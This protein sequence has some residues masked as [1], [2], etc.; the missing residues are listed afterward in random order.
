VKQDE[1]QD[2][3]SSGEIL[4]ALD[5]ALVEI[6]RLKSRAAE[7]V[8]LI[9]LGCR[10][11]GSDHGADFWN[12]LDGQR[13]G[14]GTVSS[15]RWDLL[16]HG[17]PEPDASDVAYTRTGAFLQ[18][19]D[20]FDAEF[21][22]VSP[23]E[24][25]ALDPQQRLVLEVAWEA[26][27]DAG[28]DS[29]R[30][31]NS[32]VGVFIGM[33][34]MDYATLLTGAPAPPGPYHATGVQ[35]SFASGRVS[36]LLGLRGP[37]LSVNTSCSSSLVSVHLACQ[38]LRSGESDL[39]LAGGVNL[40]LALESS[41]VLC[42]MH[43]LSPEGR[44][45]TF[46]AAADGFVRGEGCGIVVLKRLSD[47]LRDRDHI[48]AVIR[49]SAVNQDGARGG[50]T[51]PNGL[52]QQEVI[53]QALHNGGVSAAEVSYIEAHG[54]GTS[55]GDPIEMG[56]L[57]QVFGPS[58]TPERPL[59]VGSVKTNIGHLEAAAGIAGLIKV[60]L[61][62]Q[63]GQ[64][65]AH[66]HFREPNPHIAWDRLPVRIPT[67]TQ[68]W[69]SYGSR[70]VAGVSSFGMSGTNA[71]VIVEEAPAAVE[72]EETAV[73]RPWH[74]LTVSA[75]TG[76][77]LSALC[78][79]YAQRLSM[80][81]EPLGDLCYTA[82]T[83]RRHWEHRLCVLARDRSEAQAQLS[84]FDR[85]EAAGRWWSGEMTAPAGAVGFVFGAEGADGPHWRALYE[86]QPT[87]RGAVDRCLQGWGGEVSAAGLAALSGEQAL[88][89]VQYGLSE[90]WRS[91]GVEPAV[92]MGVGVGEYAAGVVSGVLEASTILSWLGPGAVAGVDRCNRSDR[93]F[94]SGIYGRVV[95]EEIQEREYWQEVRGRAGRVPE[96]LK[97]MA[98]TGCRVV[99]E[100]GSDGALASRGRELGDGSILWVSSLR[101][102]EP[103]WESV[104]S[105]LAEAY[106]RG[107]SV[108]WRGF[109]R[110]YRRRKVALPTYPWQR[111]RYWVENGT[112][113]GQ[114]AEESAEECGQYEIAWRERPVPRE[115][116]SPAENVALVNVRA[117]GQEKVRSLEAEESRWSRYEQI[118]E[119]LNQAATGQL[120]N[121][122]QGM[123]VSFAS[124]RRYGRDALREMVGVADRHR[125]LWERCMAILCERGIVEAE[126]TEWRMTGVGTEMDRGDSWE[127]L[128]QKY[129]QARQ[130]VSLLTRCTAGLGELLQGHKSAGELLGS[131]GQ[132]KV[133]TS[134]YE[135][136]PLSQMLDGP[137]GEGLGQIVDQYPPD[138]ALRILEIGGGTGRA[139]L[140]M[141][142]RCRGD[143][144]QYVFT[145]RSGLL[146]AG[147][148]ERLS[149]YP[150]VRYELL[151]IEQR[152]EDQGQ[153]RS[154]YDVIVASNVIHVTRDVQESLRHIH[155]LLAPGGILLLQEAVKPQVWVDLTVGLDERWWSYRDEAVRGSYPL[156]SR[157][158]WQSQLEGLGFSEC[159]WVGPEGC[160]QQLLMA[161]RGGCDGAH[162][163]GSEPWVVFC[164]AGGVGDS[165]SEALES[166]GD[167]CVRVYRGDAYET[168]GS[169]RYR[170][171]ARRMEEYTRIL[172][173][174][175][176]SA[177]GVL[178]LWGMDV[179][180]GR[181][182]KGEALFERSLESCVGLLGVVQ[183]ILKRSVATKVWV[184]TR[185]VQ[186]V[187]GAD[188][189]PGVGQSVLWGLSRVVGLEHG[190]L[191]CACV[192]LPEGPVGS[193]VEA[194][195]S[196]LSGPDGEDQVAYREGRRYVAR[197]VR[198]PEGLHPEKPFRVRPEGTYLIT[199]GFGSLGLELA[200]WLV[201][202]G[203]RHLVLLGRQGCR[204]PLGRRTL[205]D[206]RG[207]GVEVVEAQADVSDRSSLQGVLERIGRSPWPLRGVI[208]AAG[209][210]RECKI[211]DLNAEVMAEVC[212]PKVLGTCLLHELTQGIDLDFMV[213]MSSAA[214]V[215][216]VLG[217]G[218]YSAANA[219]LDGFAR[220]RRARG[221]VGLSV[222]WGL[223]ANGRMGDPYRD[224]LARTGVHELSIDAV[225]QVLA[226]LCCSG[227]SQ[228]IVARLDWARF[229]KVYEFA[230][231]VP[232]IEEIETVGPVQAPAEPSGEMEIARRLLKTPAALR[233]HLLTAYI[234]AKV[235]HALGF[236][237]SASL[238]PDRSFFDMGMDSVTAVDLQN[239]LQKDLG[240]TISAAAAYDH[241]TI[242]RLA[243]YVN[244]ILM[245][246]A[247]PVESAGDSSPAQA[248]WE[249][250]VKR[251]ERANESDLDGMF[252]RVLSH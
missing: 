54:T 205:S 82:N 214:S 70:R 153:K 28:Y 145:D 26:I 148:R 213:F 24:A 47:A 223:I 68:T 195:L 110:D 62:L 140:Q 63:H 165:L 126:P 160:W 184:V 211:A 139:S 134:W 97:T 143:R 111:Q 229:K 246:A 167:R 42:R 236:A 128:V 98:D 244:T 23:R 31:Y 66:L 94:V 106:V 33:A 19:V 5:R 46:D 71:H 201:G 190:A 163:S 250:T 36:Y 45:K 154:S 107:A 204:S 173:E 102:G 64:I 74:L 114:G 164:D 108:D 237:E 84:A 72:E 194:L 208:H 90:L 117:R 135:D 228:A 161:R 30:L 218:A 136:S 174:N 53:R 78:R 197:L 216:G 2:G 79:R 81:D 155:E 32:P 187:G 130:E 171:S 230:G 133:W 177:L 226:D 11:P 112:S 51:V 7:P 121:V 189:S 245:E 142:A 119:A 69:P 227:P 60:V 232:F 29:D 99:V 181:V 157:E 100:L 146:L 207:Q 238:P 149:G 4:A 158:S 239:H 188:G 200:Q 95:Q 137:L 222:N 131:A 219:F 203:A 17:G 243:D 65:P 34:N 50:L 150:F 206:L 202:A 92:V 180:Q 233:K 225:C 241:P 220:D 240:L 59:Y 221:L 185:G 104:L 125:R 224:W 242:D 249:A 183:S 101:C 215:L 12:L 192:D 1:I 162:R 141:L 198:R 18:N 118:T 25:A 16:T 170:I 58:H 166:R 113:K 37:S 210:S 193:C 15:E 44:C 175:G 8:A 168:L 73:D 105:A 93:P 132:G 212:R 234:R 231:P 172:D 159:A 86:T 247:P 122:L 20:G 199:G 235:S 103:A 13:E 209:V 115:A 56:A 35:T 76:A 21:F 123:G 129:P 3:C 61:S 57:G 176:S 6:E 67:T 83:G 116:A 109:D 91:W 52:A 49:G 41:M 252:R 138:R 182:T 186:S 27:E 248:D 147:A 127:P 89:S 178:Y 144:T 151:D 88:F 9:G 152:P 43:A 96:A 196:E 217:Q 40:M 169:G 80:G 191:G 251:M 179:D 75:R 156:L 85:G 39:A 87:F 14:V 48:L 10:F 120:I 124:G 55:L 22:R 77:A 38:S